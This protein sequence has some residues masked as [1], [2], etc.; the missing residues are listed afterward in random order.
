MQLP[1]KAV[2]NRLMINNFPLSILYQC[3]IVIIAIT[4]VFISVQG[5][6]TPEPPLPGFHSF[7]VIVKPDISS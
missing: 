4:I 6:T 1:K 7:S 5:V 2:A 3:F